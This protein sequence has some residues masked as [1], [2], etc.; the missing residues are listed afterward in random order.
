MIRTWRL[1]ARASL[2]PLAVG[3]ALLSASCGV[4]QA[5]AGPGRPPGPTVLLS[6]VVQASP[7]CPVE[8]QGQPCKPDPV[9]NVLVEA[10]SLP[11]GVTARTRTSADGHYLLRLRRGR[12]VL[13]VTTGQTP[14]RCP[15]VHIF[16]TSLAPVRADIPCD[17][18]I[19]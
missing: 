12:Y 6:G 18:G 10:R 2:P 17:S 5:T 4:R 7:G 9:G 15:H 8:R 1:V 11:T 16:V 19:R 14:T 13:T 3:L